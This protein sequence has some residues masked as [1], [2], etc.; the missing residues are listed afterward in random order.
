MISIA[1]VDVRSTSDR[2]RT[3]SST[4][5]KIRALDTMSSK[6]FALDHIYIEQQQSNEDDIIDQFHLNK[7]KKRSLKQKKVT[8]RD[9]K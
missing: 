5:L 4:P 6:A 1:G 9:E 8:F 7:K 2:G 3:S